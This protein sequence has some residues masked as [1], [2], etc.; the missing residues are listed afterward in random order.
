[1]YNVL[2]KYQTVKLNNVCNMIVPTPTFRSL[3]L[4]GRGAAGTQMALYSSCTGSRSRS[5]ASPYTILNRPRT[6]VR[7]PRLFAGNPDPFVTNCA[8]FY[9][10]ME[11]LKARF[12]IV[13]GCN[14]NVKFWEVYCD[15]LVRACSVVRRLHEEK[16]YEWIFID[17]YWWKCIHTIYVSSTDGL[18]PCV[19]SSTRFKLS[20]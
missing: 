7:K 18:N 20:S 8:R 17:F 5:T 19:S 2:V 12:E 1:M 9:K 6:Q 3:T 16:L 11:Q 14:S 10:H 15:N 4:T 13:V